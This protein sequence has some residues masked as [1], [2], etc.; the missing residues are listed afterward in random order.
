MKN[1]I[2]CDVNKARLASVLRWLTI[3]A[4]VFL[5][6]VGIWGI[7]TLFTTSVQALRNP[8]G[9]IIL[10]YVSFFGAIIIFGEFGRPRFC[11]RVFGFLIGRWGRALFQL[12]T[13]SLAITAGVSDSDV[14]S[15]VLLIIG[16]SIIAIFSFFNAFYG[17]RHQFDSDMDPTKPLSDGE[18]RGIAGWFSR[19]KTSEAPP[20]VTS[21]SGA[22]AAGLDLEDGVNGAPLAGT[23]NP[24]SSGQGW[25]RGSWL[26]ATV[27]PSGDGRGGDRS[28]DPNRAI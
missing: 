18:R 10:L 15:K 21:E 17:K 11:F 23:T 24:P 4:G 14:V 19:K 22:N 2:F 8:L 16:G 28:Q 1:C 25:K 27:A 9:F 20:A 12:F 6:F 26:D 13:G 3:L 5:I 7:V